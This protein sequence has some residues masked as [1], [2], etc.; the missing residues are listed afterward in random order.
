[1]LSEDYERLD[2]HLGEWPNVKKLRDLCNELIKRG[3]GDCPV[4]LAGIVPDMYSGPDGEEEGVESLDE[5][6]QE[7]IEIDS[8]GMGRLLSWVVTSIRVDSLGNETGNLLVLSNHNNIEKYLSYE[9]ED[10]QVLFIGS[11]TDAIDDE[12]DYEDDDD[13]D[14][15]I[16][17]EDNEDDEYEEDEDGYVR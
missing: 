8:I 1:M 7:L 9:D 17:E 5:F 12:Y 3:Y 11:P 6:T 10:H 2:F 14:D 15:E 13:D 16:D 4:M